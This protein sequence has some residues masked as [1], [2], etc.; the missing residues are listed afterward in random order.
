MTLSLLL[1]VSSIRFTCLCIEESFEIQIGTHNLDD[2]QVSIKSQQDEHMS[3]L[4]FFPF[5]PPLFFEC[6]QYG[7]ISCCVKEDGKE[8]T[9]KE[10]FDC[11]I[12][13]Y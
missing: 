5:A 6:R 8:H 13:T 9:Y 4:N 3:C 11:I 10:L 1:H 12:F 7:P 2:R